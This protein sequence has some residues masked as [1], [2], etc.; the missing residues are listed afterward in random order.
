MEVWTVW[1]RVNDWPENGG[2]DYLQL[3]FKDKEG[4]E[5]YCERRS[6]E[7]EEDGE[8]EISFYVEAWPVY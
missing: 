1:E 4:A 8:E 7:A 2:G 6:K 3:I 5:K